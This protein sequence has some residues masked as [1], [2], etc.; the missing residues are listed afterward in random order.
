MDAKDIPGNTEL[1]CDKTGLQSL[2]NHSIRPYIILA[3]NHVRP[4]TLFMN[5]LTQN[6][7]ILYHLFESIGYECYLLEPSLS[8]LASYRI[9][10]SQEMIRRKMNIHAFIEIGMSI[11]PLTRQFLRSV[12][13][14]IIKIYLG[15]I[16][17]I[18]IETIQNYS[19]INF[20]HHVVGELD[21]IWTSPHY[22]QHIE[23]AALLNHVPISKGHVVPYVWDPC[24]L[25]Q[26]GN[27]QTM[28]WIPSDWKKM[29]I[30]IMDPNISFQ[31]VAFYSILLCQAFA[32]QCPEWVG[33]VHVVNGDRFKMNSHM[34]NNIL[35]MIS[36]YR[37]GRIV[38]QDRQT[39]HEIL[40]ANASSCFV[41]HQW[42]NDYN[43]ATLELMYCNYPVVHNSIGWSEYGYY[44]SLD[45]WDN[46]V[47]TLENAM[48][49]HASHIYTYQSHVA[50]LIWKHNVHNPDIQSQWRKLIE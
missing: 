29:N 42:N 33:K 7:L 50:Q 31:K 41:T 5:G 45:N 28:N 35:P 9:I 21:E 16:L 6:I 1:I 8:N 3:T 12:G 22:S 25:N 34:L 10:Q 39:I 19:Q 37:N 4:D 20:S 36:L 23:Y 44:Y 11:D 27:T 30:V 14:K 15:N 18:D 48:K 49:Y 17:N 13:A 32:N 46:A 47:K 38:L 24:F 43:Y 26:Y 40:E 2:S